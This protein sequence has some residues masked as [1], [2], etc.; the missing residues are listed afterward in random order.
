MIYNTFYFV[1]NSYYKYYFEPLPFLHYV[2]TKWDGG[3]KGTMKEGGFPQKLFFRRLHWLSSGH[4][5]DVIDIFQQ[6]AREFAAEKMQMAPTGK[7]MSV[8]QT[9]FQVY[10]PDN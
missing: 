3:W 5:V 2:P 8:F 7:A 4:P 10:T 9:N 6:K 1:Y